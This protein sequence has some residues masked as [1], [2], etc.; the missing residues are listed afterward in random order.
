MAENVLN[1]NMSSVLGS[2]VVY[3]LFEMSARFCFDNNAKI[4]W[5][6]LNFELLGTS[7]GGR[8]PRLSENGGGR[9]ERD[10]RRRRRLRF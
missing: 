9:N 2:G 3:E 1:G 6:K 10:K 4:G 7:R 5:S 8:I